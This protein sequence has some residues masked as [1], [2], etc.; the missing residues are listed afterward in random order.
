MRVYNITKFKAVPFLVLALGLGGLVLYAHTTKT[1][2]SAPLFGFGQQPSS[3]SAPVESWASKQKKRQVDQRKMTSDEMRDEMN[4]WEKRQYE[5]GAA[6][7]WRDYHYQLKMLDK[8]NQDEI[9]AVVK[10]DPGQ[11]AA[12]TEDYKNYRAS[13]VEYQEHELRRPW[14]LT[15]TAPVI[16]AG[17]P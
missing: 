7:R 8:M 16:T 13:I 9:A 6:Q 17:Q 12:M 15:A 14:P 11:A 1:G 10:T 3:A 2:S 4:T 5:Q